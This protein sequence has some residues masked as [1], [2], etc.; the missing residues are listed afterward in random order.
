GFIA[1]VGSVPWVV[2]ATVSPRMGKASSSKKIK[3]VQAAGVSRSP[4]QRR[5]LWFPALI[6]G[7]VLVGL[8]T[9]FFARDHR[10]SQVAEAPVANQ[11]HWHAAFG[12]D[13]CGAFE[14]NQADVKADASGIHTHADGL[15]HIHPYTAASEGDNA[16]FSVFADQIGLDVSDGKFALSDG[17]TWKN[18]DKCK[19]EKTKK[20]VEGRVAMFVWPPQSTDKTEPKEVTTNIGD[21]R[22][23][24]DGQVFVLAFLPKGEVPTL[25]PSMDE[26]ASPS[27]LEAP[28]DQGSTKYTTT[29]PPAKESSTTTSAPPAGG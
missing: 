14:K 1:R 25:P 15:I 9:V 20:E 22:L 19:D 17:T 13:V 12:I 8:V 6:V 23:A 16:T 3:R 27:D 10:R 11:D 2:A 24:Q 4:G 29:V 18:G 28:P 7:I 26:L 21:I 5:T